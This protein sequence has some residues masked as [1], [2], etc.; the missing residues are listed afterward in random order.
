MKVAFLSSD[1]P[2]R[3]GGIS[4]YILQMSGALREAG[5]NTII[6]TNHMCGRSDIE[7]TEYATIYRIFTKRDMGRQCMGGK[8]LEIASNLKVDLIEG[9]DHLGECDSLLRV[10]HDIPIMVK[11]HCSNAVKV[12]W[13]SEVLY[14]WQKI[15]IK[16]AQLKKY[17]TIKAEIRSIRKAD[18][19]CAPSMRVIQEL[20]RQPLYKNLEL[21]L[22]PN[23]YKPIDVPIRGMNQEPTVLFA[24]RLSFGKGISYLPKIM[25]KVWESVPDCRLI[26]AGN[27]SYARGIGSLKKWL[28]KR[29]EKD[30]HKITFTGNIP[31]DVLVEMYDRAWV[32]IIPSRWDNFPSVA[33]EA[34][35][36]E[37]PIV[38]SP[39]GGMPEM[40]ENTGN[41]VADP[42]KEDFARGICAFLENEVLRRAAGADG[43]ARVKSVYAPKAIADQYISYVEQVMG[44]RR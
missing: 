30:I 37:R 33:L 2:C 22:I 3:G 13:S 43:S 35:A 16:F 31:F 4:S 17:Q 1:I 27:D 18:I 8:A 15:L 26:L 40:L 34:M 5:H 12:L 29:F 23:P 14:P 25:A 44:S 10:S 7:E 39:H 36:R 32:V 21:G 38:A 11:V 42:E 9:A 24:G 6:L 41:I 20:K 28:I 19:L